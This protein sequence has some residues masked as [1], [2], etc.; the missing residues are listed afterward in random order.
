[1]FPTEFLVHSMA[2]LYCDEAWAT[3]GSMVLPTHFRLEAKYA[4]QL[5]SY[6]ESAN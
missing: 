1:M 2:I 5:S 3:C 4:M 6:V